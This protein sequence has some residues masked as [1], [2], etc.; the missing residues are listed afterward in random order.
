MRHYS[1]HAPK[2]KPM[3]EELWQRPHPIQTIQPHKDFDPQKVSV[4]GDRTVRPLK[5]WLLGN[6]PPEQIT[7]THIPG[8]PDT[9]LA[10][11]KFRNA[12]ETAAFTADLTL[13]SSTM[14]DLNTRE[15][16]NTN[17][18]LAAQVLSQSCPNTGS[19]LKFFPSSRHRI[20]NSY[21]VQLLRTRFGIPCVNEP[22]K[23]KCNCAAQGVFRHPEFREH[24]CEPQLDDLDAD[25]P[26]FATQPLH[27]LIGCRRRWKRVINRHNSVRD[28]L[29]QALRGIKNVQT[30]LEPPVHDLGANVRADIEVTLGAQTWLLDVGIVCPASAGWIAKKSNVRP[31]AAGRSYHNIKHQKYKGKVIPV[32]IETGGRFDEAGRDF[33]DKLASTQQDTHQRSN[34]ATHAVFNKVTLTLEKVQMHMMANL[35]REI[36]QPDAAAAQPPNAHR[37]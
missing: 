11:D 28:S 34:A 26:S 31:G 25:Q 14:Q 7:T 1:E 15:P 23:R 10:Y 2:F 35:V 29:A 27:G 12:T 17:Q 20:S 24:Y 8:V 18:Q 32:I 13:H 33:I 30:R 4:K 6:I 5:G 21:F 19:L 37:D 36:A 22:D 3:L 16:K 9:T